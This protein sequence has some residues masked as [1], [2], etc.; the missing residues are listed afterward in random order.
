MP[1]SVPTIAKD[2]TTPVIV[3]ALSVVM[4]SLSLLVAHCYGVERG[5]VSP[6]PNPNYLGNTLR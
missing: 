5:R 4:M 3:F 2:R 6:S 1:I